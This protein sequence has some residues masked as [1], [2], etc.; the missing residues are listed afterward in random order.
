MEAQPQASWTVTSQ[1]LIPTSASR[2]HAVAPSRPAAPLSATRL[3][4]RSAL[5]EQQA[6]YHAQ[7][8]SEAPLGNAAQ[9]GSGRPVAAAAAVAALAGT[10]AACYAALSAQPQLP[11]LEDVLGAAACAL[12]GGPLVALAAAKAALR[13]RFHV[14]LHRGR[15]YLQA[16]LPASGAALPPNSVCVRPTGDA[17]GNGAFAAAPIPA[18]TYLGDYTGELL[19]R[20]AFY[21]RHPDGVG[22]FAA[23]IDDEWTI[24]AA[25]AVG[26][27]DN[28]HPVHMNHSARRCN[29]ARYYARS[30]RRIAFFTTRD[31]AAGEELLY[32]YGRAYWRGREHLE[33]P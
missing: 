18:G 8:Q 23:A 5:A 28:F 30:Q 22:D 19:D 29:V 10:G 17:R 11:P 13:D 33:L 1:T 16:G 20:A 32:D 6:Q 3:E 31:V 2:R 4:Q 27:V 21:A 9:Q 25:T 24:D 15:L 12:L 7:H 26:D 14:E